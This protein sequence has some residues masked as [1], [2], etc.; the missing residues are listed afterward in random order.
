MPVIRNW[1]PV[2]QSSAPGVNVHGGTIK[3]TQ[4]VAK[5]HNP[6]AASH[7]QYIGACEMKNSAGTFIQIW[8][9]GPVIVAIT[10]PGGS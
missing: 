6:G 5:R 8:V 2:K 3:F 1:I 7:C 9:V 10:G 4:N